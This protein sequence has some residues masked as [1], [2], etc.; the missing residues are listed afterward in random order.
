M[1]MLT[2]SRCPLLLFV[3]AVL[4]GTALCLLVPGEAIESQ[5]VAEDDEAP[6]HF[7]EHL[8]LDKYGYAYGIAA[9][10]IDRDGN[11]D[12]TT[13]DSREND[14]GTG[15]SL[16]W[17]AN[18]G[19]GNFKRYFIQTNEPKLLERHVVG[20]VNGDGRLDV[21]VVKNLGNQVLWFENSGTPRDG[22][23]WKRHVITS[24]LP[25]AYDVCLTDLD[26]D[27][28]LDV[29]ASSYK[30][31]QIAWF[32]NPVKL[33][34]DPEWKKHLI[35]DK[36]DD[37]RTIRAADFNGDDRRDLL[38]TARASNLVLWYENPGRPAT[39]PWKRHVIDD[40]AIH[41][42]HGHPVDLDGDGDIDVVMAVGMLAPPGTKNSHQIV[43]YENVGK[44]GKGLEWKK[45]VIGELE[46]AF[47][48]VAADLD[49]DGH[50]DVV[51][52]SWSPRGQL[53]WFHNPGDPRGKWKKYV[54]KDN[55]SHANQVIVADL[56]K[57]G[58]PDIIACAEFGANELRWWRNEGRRKDR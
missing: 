27:G 30:G 54:L 14:Q 26:G 5:A 58:R 4:A 23:L 10:D 49:G 29:A 43:W 45:H 28:A 17:L 47:E 50:I 6:I 11:L 2:V 33:D 36:L 41:P 20:D 9:A 32:A 46:N 1:R 51:A 44:P 7:T 31:G 57:D 40:Q 52:T 18:D 24:D 16:S 15:L 37:T 34:G 8:I 19:K 56:N 12:L 13:A 21:V 25:R 3:L 48:V 53:V 42:T 38:A 35:E 39:G 22:Q 55:W